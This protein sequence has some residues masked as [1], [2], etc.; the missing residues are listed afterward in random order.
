MFRLRIVPP[1]I[2]LAILSLAAGCNKGGLKAEP[3]DDNFKLDWVSPH[4][5]KIEKDGANDAALDVTIDGPVASIILMSVDEKTGAAA[6]GQQW[7]TLVENDVVPKASGSTFMTGGS[8]WQLG[9]F[10]NGGI[11]NTGSGALSP[12]GSGPHKLK[13]FLSDN[14]Q[15]RTL[16]YV[17][18]A[19]RPDGTAV[20]SS[21]FSF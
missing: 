13:L 17:V 2:G 18:V 3:A 5:G 19:M 11:K 7:D 10:E 16:K 21:V 9:V 1:A 4:D 15:L 20:R 6:N 14:G 8:T 12:L